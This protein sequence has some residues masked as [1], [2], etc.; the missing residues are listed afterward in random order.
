MTTR[1]P[2]PDPPPP[3]SPLAGAWGLEPGLTFLNH[4]SFGA[5]P[6]AVL[7][8]QSRLRARLEA[9]PVRFF[10]RDLE[11]LIDE[12]RAA[13]AGF[14]G[15]RADD[16][17]FVTNATQAVA[18]VLANVEPHLRPGDELLYTGHEY[19][20]CMNA[21]RRTA[22]RT[23]AVTA[24]APL[25]WP[26]RSEAALVEAV[27]SRVTPRTRLLLVSHVTSPTGLVLPLDRIVPDLE[28][29][30][31]RCLVDGAHAPGLVAGLDLTRLGAS[32]YT[33]N[34]HKWL[35]TPKGCG[36]LHVRPDRQGEGFRP[37][38]LS[39][40]AERPKPGRKHLLTEFDYVGTADPT[41]WL[42][43]AE[44]I[45]VVGGMAP[46]GWPEVMR[47]NRELCL[48][49]RRLLCGELGVEPPAPESLLA[50]LATIPLPTEPDPARRAR[51]AARPS[52]NHDAL[53]DRLLDQWRIQV[54]VW[55]I[56]TD[57]PPRRLLRV[58]AQLYNTIEQYQ[59]LAAALR[60]ELAAE[61]R[62]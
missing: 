17:V 31:V 3:A 5:T 10:V 12:N 40:N 34:L 37:L 7:E 54:P 48:R 1:P 2:T 56:P 46:G 39:N 15:C 20:A 4:G 61:S 19:P 9:D 6:R 26:A 11:G 22:S 33:A 44:A 8:H 51:L 16:L 25:P 59:Y 62:A 52:A 23:G 21:L 36:V 18:T 41:A 55:S 60:E 35:C 13:A 28:A 43:V 58:S 42:C 53:W 49:A 24:M 45:R 32:Y 47:R 50:A 27:L 29:R 57:D 30:G 38:A 14:L